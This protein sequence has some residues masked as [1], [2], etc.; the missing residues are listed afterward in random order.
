MQHVRDAH[1]G[2][3][4]VEGKASCCFTL[5]DGRQ[6]QAHALIEG[7]GWRWHQHPWEAGV[8]YVWLQATSPTYGQVT[9]V[10]GDELGRIVSL[11]CVWRPSGAHHS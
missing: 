9:V 1:Q 5:A 4:L 10:I 7:Q 11:C 6:L 3:L 2:T 8:R